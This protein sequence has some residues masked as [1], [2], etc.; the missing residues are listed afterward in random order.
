M[1]NDLRKSLFKISKNTQDIKSDEN[2]FKDDNKADYVKK[3]EESFKNTYEEFQKYNQRAQALS[4]AVEK[5]E[6]QQK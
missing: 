5:Y 3:L 2:W 6:T 1:K 4:S